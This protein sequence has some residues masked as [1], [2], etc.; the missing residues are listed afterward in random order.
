[1]ATKRKTNKEILLSYIATLPDE[2][3]REAYY[4]LQ[5]M[6]VPEVEWVELDRVRITRGQYTK[7]MWMWGEEKTKKCVEI[8]N[9]WIKE[10][11]I[12]KNISC[13]HNL[14]TWVEVKYNQ[15]NG[16]ASKDI[17]FD[18]EFKGVKR[19]REYIRNIP[20]ELRAYDREVRFLVEK[21]G[22]KALDI[23]D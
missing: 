2:R 1:M 16:L 23:G 11:G 5:D 12:T 18:S 21:F 14:L 4:I 22:K 20:K 15:M 7:L 10:K 3:C 17:R 9:N 13:Y 19:A 6:E 8:L